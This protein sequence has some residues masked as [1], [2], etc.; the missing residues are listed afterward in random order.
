[1]QHGI[2]YNIFIFKLIHSFILTN[3]MSF[4]DLFCI[5]VTSASGIGSKP[6]LE[7]RIQKLKREAAACALRQI[8]GKQV[9]IKHS[10]VLDVAALELGA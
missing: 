7:S 3:N 1:M 5:P 6:R 10:A 9:Q 4:S 2:L 8:Q